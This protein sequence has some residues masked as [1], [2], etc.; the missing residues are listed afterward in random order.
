M[1]LTISLVLACAALNAGA[2]QKSSEF[3]AGLRYYEAAEFRKAAAHFQIPCS[4]DG[5]A[6]ACYW[7][8]ISYERLAD[9]R[10]PFGCGIDTKARQYLRQ[11]VKLAPERPAYREAFFDF[12][13]DTA[14]CS[15]TALQEAAELLAAT[16]ERGAGYDWMRSRLEEERRDKASVSGRL[17]RLL[18]VV[19]RAAYRAGALPGAVLTNSMPSG[20]EK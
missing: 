13:L 16:P 1:K 11:A 3:D 17:G 5:N 8:G 9:T 14:G 20:L 2:A 12:L 18:L 7:T 15:R 19:P 6:E 10:T 4:V